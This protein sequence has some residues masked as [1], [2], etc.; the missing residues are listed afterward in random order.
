MWVTM[1]PGQRTLAAE[2]WN[3]NV[4]PFFARRDFAG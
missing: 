3:L 2:S 4:G 1:T